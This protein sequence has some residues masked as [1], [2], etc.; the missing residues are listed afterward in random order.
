MNA[1]WQNARDKLRRIHERREQLEQTEL[2]CRMAEEQGHYTEAVQLRNT[3]E[4]L[5]DMIEADSLEA[6]GRGRPSQNRLDQA[7]IMRVVT[8][9]TGIPMTNLNKEENEKLRGI[10]DELHGTIV[11]QDKAVSA[12]AN[13]VRRNR[14]G[15]GDADKP[16]GSFLF[17]GNYRHGQDG[18]QQGAGIL[19]LFDS[20]DMMV[21]IDMSE[22]QEKHNVPRPHRHASRICGT[23]RGR[24]ANRGRAPATI[25]GGAL[26]RNRK[27]RIPTCS[28]GS[29]KCSTKVAL[30]D[31][32]G[33]VVNFKE[34]H[35]HYDLQHG[36][37][38]SSSSASWDATTPTTT[39]R[40]CRSSDAAPQ[41]AGPPEFLNRIEEVVMFSV[42]SVEPTLPR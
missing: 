13:V 2:N 32:K 5:R 9:W 35:H 42:R 40:K 28:R 23:R 39:W 21:R 6:P 12:V 22:Y 36:V 38:S 27:R 14:M 31:G 10:E 34:H 8:D 41:G 7:D 37:R 24:T 25:L 33:R 3:A 16:I 4:G 15:L 29:C 20:K 17:L 19:P 18:A 11:G 26:R 30:T 1:R